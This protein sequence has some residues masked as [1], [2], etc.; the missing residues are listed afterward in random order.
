MIYEVLGCEK[1]ISTKKREDHFHF[2]GYSVAYS[3]QQANV[4]S[5]PRILPQ[6]VHTLE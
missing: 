5:H 3:N 6:E 2:I 1:E 4:Y